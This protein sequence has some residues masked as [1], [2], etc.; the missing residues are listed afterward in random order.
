[1]RIRFLH[2]ENVVID[3][4]HP[5]CHSGAGVLRIV[6]TGRIIDV[7]ALRGDPNAKIITD[8]PEQVCRVLDISYP[9]AQIVKG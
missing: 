6:G 8:E 2:A 3:Q 4:W 7:D 5:A 1:M 9:D